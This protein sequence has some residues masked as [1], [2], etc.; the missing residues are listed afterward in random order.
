MR[1]AVAVEELLI[2]QL[3]RHN[4][5]VE[6]M[7]TAL[8]IWELEENGDFRLEHA[9]AASEAATG[10]K[11]ERILG[12]TMREVLPALPDAAYEQFVDVV[13]RRPHLGSARENPRAVRS[14]WLGQEH[15]GQAPATKLSCGRRVNP[16]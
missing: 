7:Q 2:E 15:A 4:Q 9:N 12:R 6:H 8:W 10:L 14:E 16:Y 3:R 5:V 13:R 11:G 1:R